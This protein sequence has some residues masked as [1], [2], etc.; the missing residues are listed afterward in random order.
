M[1]NVKEILESAGASLEE[2]VVK[3]QYF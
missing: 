2:D 1:K 3:T